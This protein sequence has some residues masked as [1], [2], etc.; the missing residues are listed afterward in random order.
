M[1][2]NFTLFNRLFRFSPTSLF[3]T[4][5]ACSF[6]LPNM[7]L[8]LFPHIQNQIGEASLH[9][10]DIASRVSGIYFY[11]FVF[12]ICWITAN[13]I[14]SFPIFKPNDIQYGFNSTIS[15]AGCV[16][17]IAAFFI[18]SLIPIAGL[19]AAVHIGIF[20]CNKIPNKSAHTLSAPLAAAITLIIWLNVIWAIGNSK[21]M[22]IH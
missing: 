20:I 2:N 13:F 11:L 21:P 15:R 8:P 10:I 16:Q 9:G 22:K 12:V 1:E 17:V 3:Y 6:F 14:F 19:F 7:N 18:P 5:L 4:L